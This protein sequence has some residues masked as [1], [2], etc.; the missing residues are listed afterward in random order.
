[1]CRRW[2]GYG[3]SVRWVLGNKRKRARIRGGPDRRL[4]GCA[5]RT[6]R[7][8]LVATTTDRIH[9]PTPRN[10]NAPSTD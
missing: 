8:H 9:G 4:V 6:C 7:E 2:Q 5:R 1:M 3:Y 10:G